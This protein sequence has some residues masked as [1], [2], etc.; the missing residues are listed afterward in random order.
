M[1]IAPGRYSFI[2]GTVLGN[3]GQ[4]VLVRSNM[5]SD[6]TNDEYK[7]CAE[8]VSEG[9]AVCVQWKSGSAGMQAQLAS[10]TNDGSLLFSFTTA[11]LVMVIIV[12]GSE[13]HDI[14]AHTYSL[15]GGGSQVQSDWAQNDSSAV[16]FIKN[17]PDMDVYAKL[18]DLAEVAFSGDY[19]DLT[20]KPENLPTK[21]AGSYKQYSLMYS[22]NPGEMSM[23]WSLR[24][25]RN[26]ILRQA[27]VGLDSYSRIV[28]TQYM[29]DN[30]IAYIYLDKTKFPDI[31]GGFQ[32]WDVKLFGIQVHKQTADASLSGTEWDIPINV[33]TSMIATPDNDLNTMHVSTLRFKWKP[34]GQSTDYQGGVNFTV[35]LL[36]SDAKAMFI[37][38][39]LHGYVNNLAVGD[40]I[41]IQGSVRPCTNIM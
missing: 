21:P 11:N 41:Y 10:I 32:W 23:F 33:T 12:S 40:Q 26:I 16:D 35:D 31:G 9:K 1:A 6:F 8:A 28:L 19:D 34:S 7:S 15:G 39:D 5:S 14:T 13:P 25:S 22:S 37:K 29:L 18:A 3:A 2:G 24:D 38:L 30:N 20:N 27:T 36:N 17:K 4:F